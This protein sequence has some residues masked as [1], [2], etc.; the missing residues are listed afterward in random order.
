MH[1]QCCK[2]TRWS[3]F[4]R[5]SDVF[6]HGNWHLASS[7]SE[8][9]PEDTTSYNPTLIQDEV[10]PAWSVVF[11][12]ASI[13]LQRTQTVDI[14]KAKSTI[15]FQAMIH[16]RLYFNANRERR[17]AF[18]TFGPHRRTRLASSSELYVQE[19]D[20]FYPHVATDVVTRDNAQHS[21]DHIPNRIQC[22]YV[23]T[24][25]NND[26]TYLCTAISI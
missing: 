2:A 25:S 3:H 22:Y 1:M 15:D 12:I 18:Q 26:A 20:S 21:S 23:R 16:G 24:K 10:V 5:C 13:H 11:I 19:T 9:Q 4:V 8:S 7:S 17:V 14:D 6:V